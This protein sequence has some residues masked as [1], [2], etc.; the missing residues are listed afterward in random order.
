MKYEKFA[1]L[2]VVGVIGLAA[3]PFVMNRGNQKPA[4][5]NAPAPVTA[6]VK[7]EVPLFELPTPTGE[8]IALKD[9]LGKHKAVLINF[10]FNG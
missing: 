4:I 5:E 1:P 9:L 6:S 2:I 7:P 10:W 8:T 3:L